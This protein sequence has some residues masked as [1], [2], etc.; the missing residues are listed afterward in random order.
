MSRNPWIASLA[1]AFISNALSALG[2]GARA[3]ENPGE[4]LRDDLPPGTDGLTLW[5]QDRNRRACRRHA[6]NEAAGLYSD[7]GALRRPRYGHCRPYLNSINEGPTSE[8][9]YAPPFTGGQCP[10]VIYDV[11]WGAQSA[12]RVNSSTGQSAVDTAPGRTLLLRAL[13]PIEIGKPILGED[14]LVPVTFSN[15]DGSRSTEDRITVYQAPTS[16]WSY[17]SVSGVNQRVVPFSGGPDNCGDPPSEYEPPRYPT[18]LPPLP[19]SDVVPPGGDGDDDIEVDPDGNWRFCE[20]GDCTPWFTPGGGGTPADPGGEEDGDPQ[21]TNPNDPNNPNEI[22]GCVE[23]GNVLVGLKINVLEYPITYQGS[24]DIFYR[25]GWVWMGPN[26]S[27]LDLT[28]DGATIRDGQF[29]FPDGPDC[30]CYTVR[31]NPEFR[32]SVQAFSKPREENNNN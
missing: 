8:G 17:V 10:G 5:I 26:E 12:V 16:L 29:V 6:R 20:N 22:S 3:L 25:V 31:A 13:G 23:D 30:T 11:E 9:S 21:E 32:L 7:L 27:Q 18:N 14:I 24:G 28:I 4:F 1:D 19:P 2:A 15:P